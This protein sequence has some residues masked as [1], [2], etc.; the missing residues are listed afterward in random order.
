M[1]LHVTANMLICITRALNY[2]SIYG[3]EKEAPLLNALIG[4]C[5]G[6][7]AILGPV[8]GGAF[9]D[10]S[11]TWRWVSLRYWDILRA[12]DRRLILLGILYQPTNCSIAQPNLFLRVAIP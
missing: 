8:I 5:W 3:T 2:F 12:K 1:D 11:A 6:I 7:G 10:S 4:I 9:S